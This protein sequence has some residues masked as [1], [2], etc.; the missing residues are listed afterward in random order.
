M[1]HCSSCHAELAD[2]ALFCLKC[3][4]SQVSA[5][6]DPL[7]GQVVADRYLI[8]RRVG[9]GGSGTVYEARHVTLQ[10][11]VAVK[12]L[13]HHLCQD[14]VAVERF[15]REATTVAQIESPHLIGIRDFGAVGDGRLF[16]AMEYLEGETLAARLSR[17][18]PLA[19][20]ECVR[21]L[22]QVCEGLSDAHARG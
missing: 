16:L 20:A 7:I 6:E 13:H 3:G 8:R 10:Q 17:D 21:L 22:D 9:A 12:I 1:K 15:R 14:E 2:D 11:R 5:D 4:Q 18:G 19:P